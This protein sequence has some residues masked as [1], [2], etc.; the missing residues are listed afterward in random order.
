MKSSVKHQMKR[1]IAGGED[2]PVDVADIGAAD[3]LD[4]LAYGAGGADVFHPL[5][6]SHGPMAGRA[7]IQSGTGAPVLLTC[8]AHPNH[9]R[10][11]LA[12]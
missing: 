3:E 2:R 8:T 7:A 10:I 5:F 6:A 9:S 4:D 1:A 11:S 12:V